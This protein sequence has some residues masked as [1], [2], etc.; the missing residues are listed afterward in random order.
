MAGVMYSLH[1]KL[2]DS[3]GN[4]LVFRVFT[5]L[6]DQF[7][8][9]PP[10]LVADLRCF[11]VAACFVANLSDEPVIHV[12]PH[13]YFIAFHLFLMDHDAVDQRMQQF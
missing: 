1:T 9:F 12:H 8:L 6:I 2:P 7:I 11:H 5:F 10:S 3:P 4:S 13:D